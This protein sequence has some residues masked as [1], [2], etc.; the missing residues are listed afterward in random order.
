MRKNVMKLNEPI[1]ERERGR[2]V[3]LGANDK[4]SSTEDE[5]T[6]PDDDNKYI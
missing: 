2:I 4:E 1:A 6:E 5:E 3:I